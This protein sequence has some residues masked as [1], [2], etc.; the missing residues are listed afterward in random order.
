MNTLFKTICSIFTILLIS[1]HT[2]SQ[3]TDVGNN[4][5]SGFIDYNITTTNT[6]YNQ[7]TDSL[8]STLTQIYQNDSAVTFT[9]SINVAGKNIGQ[10]T[11]FSIE[12]VEGEF[13]QDFLEIDKVAVN[14]PLSYDG[15]ILTF[16]YTVLNL[17]PA[18]KYI[19]RVVPIYQAYRGFPSNLLLLK[20]LPSPINYWEPVIP[21][22]TSLAGYARGFTDPVIDRPHLTD[23]VEIFTEETSN[24]PIWFSD[25]PTMQT[26]YLPTGRRGHSLTEIDGSVYMFGGRTNGKHCLFYF[27]SDYC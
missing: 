7:T 18:S 16:V 23:G 17:S 12:L 24:N 6:I 26:P 10:P 3:D 1:I 11:L 19:V 9:W 22:R 27:L 2:K 4:L 5:A 15:S 8:F 14:S 21:R 13:N 20:T 25:S